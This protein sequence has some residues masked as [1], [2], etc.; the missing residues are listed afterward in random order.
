MSEHP[1]LSDGYGRIAIEIMDALSRTYMSSYESQFIW[2][3]FRNTYGWSKKDDW[4][5]ISKISEATN[6]QDTH[7]SRTKKKLLLRKIITQTGKKIAF[8]KYHSQWTRLPKQVSEDTPAQ[9]GNIPP[10]EQVILPPPIQADTIY[11]NKEILQKKEP[12]FQENLTDV[13][14][15]FMLAVEK[16]EMANKEYAERVWSDGISLRLENREKFLKKVRLF[17]AWCGAESQRKKA[18][19][20][21]NEISAFVRD[22]K[23]AVLTLSPAEIERRRI[24][25]EENSPNNHD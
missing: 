2:C 13:E 20:L 5:S 4:I 9:I 25:A 10:P 6:M 17:L 15:F 22:K 11:S 16:Y 14:D 21:L 7:V 3:L 18:G 19:P 24:F 1:E 12:D 23:D 8:N